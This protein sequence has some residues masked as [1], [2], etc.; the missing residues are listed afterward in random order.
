LRAV[1]RLNERI[2]K[3]CLT[4]RAFKDVFFDHGVDPFEAVL[5][6]ARL[7]EQFRARRYPQMVSMIVDRRRRS[8]AQRKRYARSRRQARPAQT[9]EGR[10]KPL[11]RPR[12]V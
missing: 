3:K 5:V 7:P 1:L 8:E 2:F 11:T 4:V 9:R 12:R 10:I 6:D